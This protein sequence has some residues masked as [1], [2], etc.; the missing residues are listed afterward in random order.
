MLRYALKPYGILPICWG[1]HY[2]GLYYTAISSRLT[3]PEM[4]YIINDCG[5]GA[6]ITS[7][8]KAQEAIELEDD[9]PHVFCDLVWEEILMATIS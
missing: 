6:F 1:A 5:A 2:A 7:T 8:Y 3:A 9:I 4:A